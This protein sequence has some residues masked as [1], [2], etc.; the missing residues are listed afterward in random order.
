MP[1]AGPTKDWPED[2]HVLT[3]RLTYERWEFAL[4][5]LRSEAQADDELL[6]ETSLQLGQ[7]A[8]DVIK[9]QLP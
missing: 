7:D 4:A 3:I 6:D 5:C 9:T 1:R 8:E 2:T